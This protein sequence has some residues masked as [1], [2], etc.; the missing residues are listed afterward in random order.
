MRVWSSVVLLVI[1]GST[2]A[3]SGGDAAWRFDPWIAASLAPLLLLRPRRAWLFGGALA[4]L[5]LALVWPLERLADASLAAHMAQ[6]MLLIGVAAP[7]LAASRPVVALLKGRGT[8]ARPLLALARPRTAFFLHGAAIWLGHAPRVIAWSLEH[9]WVHALEHL[10]LVLTAALFWWALLARGREGAGESALWTLGTML[11]TG[12]LGALLTF[13]PRVIYQATA[14]GDQQLAGLVM[15]IPGGLCY[16]AAG[17]AFA[18]VWLAG[19]ERPIG[20]RG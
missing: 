9:R 4:A 8:L 3:H 20:W 11:H 14:L 15:W 17:L 2:F 6:H 16:L 19:R 18:A 5:F 1:S 12:A 7:L 10:A 13:S